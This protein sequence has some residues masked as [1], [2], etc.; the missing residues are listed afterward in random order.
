M[1]PFAGTGG[2]SFNKWRGRLHP[3]RLAGAEMPRY[4]RRSRRAGG[5]GPIRFPL[6]GSNRCMCSGA[7]RSGR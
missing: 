4:G 3:E 1:Q 6:S 2:D 5:Y 7:K